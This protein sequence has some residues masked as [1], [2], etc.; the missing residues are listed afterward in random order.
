MAIIFAVVGGGAVVGIATYDD[1]SDHSDHS[2]YSDYYNHSDY[3]DY[4]VRQERRRQELSSNIERQE[5]FQ[6][7]NSVIPDFQFGKNIFPYIFLSVIFLCM[8]IPD[9]I[10][11]R[12][13]MPFGILQTL[14]AVTAKI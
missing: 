11:L 10:N 4:A 1:H 14:P 5:I 8:L 12:F 6:F 2:D 9:F 7:H 3:S 13:F